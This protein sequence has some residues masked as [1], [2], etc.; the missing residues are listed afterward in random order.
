MQSP[1]ETAAEDFNLV[2]AWLT[3]DT[4]RWIAGVMAG[5]FAGLV[6][7]GLGMVMS[8]VSG[9]EIWFPIKLMATIILGSTATE[10]GPQLGA[11]LVGFVLFEAICAFWGFVY[12][13]FVRT[14][15]LGALLAMGVVWGLFSWILT[16]NLFMHSFKTI[17][18]A[19]ISPAATFPVCIAYGVSLTVVVFFD[20]AMRGSR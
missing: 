20:R 5:L 19:D 16:W 6:A 12:A 15:Q 3:R 13:Q 9:M 11:I 18:A 7:L 14:N 1:T 2:E 17:M 8:A 4:T 10:L